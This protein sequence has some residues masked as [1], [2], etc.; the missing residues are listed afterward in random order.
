MAL[1]KLPG[2]TLDTSSNVTF[3][4]ANVSGNLT[5]GN[6]NLGNLVTANF[7][8]GSGNN[9]LSGTCNT[10]QTCTSSTSTPCNSAIGVHCGFGGGGG[11]DYTMSPGN[12]EGGSDGYLILTY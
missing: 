9:G 5:A 3:A 4:N 11:A 8:S 6:A 2:F 12:S 7:F 10:L 1:T